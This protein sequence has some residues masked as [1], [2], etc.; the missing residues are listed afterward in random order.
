M[1]MKKTKESYSRIRAVAV[2]GRGRPTLKGGYTAGR[3]A[4]IS[5]QA[6]LSDQGGRGARLQSANSGGS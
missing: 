4:A 6:G 3:G 1:S 2:L 5:P